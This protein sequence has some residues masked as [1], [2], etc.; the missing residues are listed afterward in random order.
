MAN[1]QSYPTLE[2]ALREFEQKI[3]YCD[4]DAQV[5]SASVSFFKHSHFQPDD[6][7]GSRLHIESKQLPA[8]SSWQ[9]QAAVNNRVSLAGSI[10][11]KSSED[12]HEEYCLNIQTL[13][14]DEQL[15][16]FSVMLGDVR[17]CPN[18]EEMTAGV[19]A[20][21]CACCI[22][23]QNMQILYRNDA[24]DE[25]VKQG[26]VKAT[27]ID[28]LFL[29]AANADSW[30][31]TPGVYK[32]KKISTQ[33]KPVSWA[34]VE[35]ASYP[36]HGQAMYSCF[37]D[38]LAS[39]GSRPV[40]AVTDRHS[41]PFNRPYYLQ[42][43]FQHGQ[44]AMA[45]TTLE[46]D[47]LMA[48]QAF[49][50]LSRYEHSALTDININDITF[51]DDLEFE[52]TTH[53][54]VLFNQG[55]TELYEK[56]LLSPLGDEVPISTRSLLIKDADDEPEAIW[57]VAREAITQN[58]LMQTL[59]ASERRFRSLFSNSIDAISF[60]ST[61][62][63]LL[64][65]N[66]AY[67]DLLGYNDEELKHLTYQALT[68]PGWEEADSHM[69]EQLKQRGYSDILEKE[70][71]RKDQVRI[72]ISVR[73]SAIKDHTGEVIGSW[74]IIRNISEQRD[75]LRK[76]QHSQ[77]LLKQTSRMSRV[78]GWEINTSLTELT[79]TEEAFQILSIPRS[80]ETSVQSLAKLF[81][82]E[83]KRRAANMLA[84]VMKGS[85]NG[86]TELKLLGFSPER[87]IRVSAQL[88]FEETGQR[89]AYGAV[90]DISDFVEQQRSLES[91][92]DNYQRLA[93]HD[94]LTGLPNRLLLA[95]R[96]QQISYQARREHKVAALML[97]DL[98][99]FKAMNDGHGH[100]AG[101]ALLVEIAQRLSRA[102]RSSDTVARLGGDEFVIIM[103]LTNEQ[104][105][106]TF[107]KKIL[108]IIEI[109]I[110]WNSA[111]LVTSASIGVALSDVQDRNYDELYAR[112]DKAL[113]SVKKSGRNGFQIAN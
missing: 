77:N 108:S 65:A 62:D 2:I 88:A 87:W 7:I 46:G 49:A 9:N 99:R 58:K 82:P 23:N 100:P 97:I 95:D 26:P 105:A 20:D 53:T 67:L 69:K 92:R 17:Q 43:L 83:S 71:M 52:Q 113:Y 30:L 63:E 110:I 76:L 93:F 50:A 68:P 74:M 60:W 48:N 35:I 104:Q 11:H 79:L 14:K 45:L 1:D 64:Y 111:E 72:P 41:P 47:I 12:E 27:H 19:K 89:Y 84:R 112:A 57:I 42:S 22:F 29:D 85:G 16:G 90:Q 86:I 6:F 59:A 106:T 54:K 25:L 33:H 10:G 56:R 96:F 102:V 66:Q 31:L 103:M 13:S 38:L 15:A 40:A 75:T 109:P 80:Y 51:K 18:K 61:K 44:D 36:A 81:D 39:A 21:V 3:L 4:K 34:H 101:D 24:F 5:L 91:A 70:V 28:A 37:I 107:A 78:G 8:N 94:A 73:A 55:H 98:D 32:N